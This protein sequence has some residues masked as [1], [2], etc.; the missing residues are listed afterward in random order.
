MPPALPLPLT[1]GQNER[2]KKDHYFK[3]VPYLPDP[4]V[5]CSQEHSLISTELPIFLTSSALDQSLKPF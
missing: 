1:A 5:S 2:G 3:T 4:G